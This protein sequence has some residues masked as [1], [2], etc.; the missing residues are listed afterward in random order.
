MAAAQS[1]VT[2]PGKCCILHPIMSPLTP[3]GAAESGAADSRVEFLP[4]G[5]SVLVP[6][7]STLV[8]AA[9]AAD[10]RIHAPCG[11][12]GRCG[13]CAV[14]MLRGAGPPTA[15]ESRVLSP[16]ELEAG[17]RLACQAR[18]AQDAQVDIP[19]SA[20]IVA[21]HIVV[22]G[23]GREVLVEPNVTKVALRLPPPSADDPRDDLNRVL[24]A[25]GH[26]TNGGLLP[27]GSLPPLAEL[28]RVL[29][30]SGWHVT[31]VVA[32]RN[33]GG[34]GP[35]L[36]G[37]EPG[38]TGD[39][40]YGV[41]V[42]IG[43][44]TLVVYLS[45]LPSGNLVS[46]ASDLNPQSQYGEDVISRLQ[47]AVAGV[48]TPALQECVAQAIDRLVGSAAAEGGIPRERIYEISVVGNTCMSHLFLGIDPV[49][50]VRLPFV[51]AFRRAQT[52][53]AA[54]LGISIHPE[55]QVYLLPNIGGWVGA[56]TVGVI[57]A[58]ELDQSKGL[59]VA[60]DIGTNGEIVVSQ[61][62][63][64]WACS[65]AAGPAFEGA[66]ISQGMRAAAGAIDH[67]AINGDVACHVI[68][69]APPV[70]I[71]GSG[72]V[73]AVAALVRLGVVDER[74]RLRGREEVEGLPEKVGE[75]LVQNEA[76]RAFVLAR[77]E[78]SGGRPVAITAR[79]IRESQLAKGAIYAGIA[80]VLELL[81]RTPGDIER[82][83][84]AGAFGNYIRR[85]SA[86]AIGL[87]PAIPEERIF[88]VGNA[89]GLGA[90]LALCSTSLRQRAEE[91]ARRTHHI[92]LSEQEGF[93]D[94]FAEAMALR[95]LPAAPLEP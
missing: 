38:D 28:P 50:L 8:A 84:L 7:Q 81:G 54:D 33:G 18:V 85:E 83:L 94:C 2:G 19:A 89:A 48:G 70:G 34:L 78:E 65:T 72:L 79:D 92:E 39:E 42:D 57:L 35:A 90:R 75:R 74:G 68:G 40:A 93:Y 32:G 55:G 60:V 17:W 88:S 56:D 61:D 80:L 11:G 47:V 36:L 59:Q 5:R 69:G 86:I 37:V 77:A 24:D 45:H 66:K 16:E 71:C 9:A 58:S 62:G 15:A 13:K 91:I 41:A 14:R 73:D 46:I 12:Q 95:P 26:A 25:M 31:A 53:R 44:T 3:T 64:L 21:H 4:S 6:A 51:P 23:L 27:P 49:G 52:V 1:S 22:E 43:T 30:T 82:L 76:G 63:E 67:V 29:R 20:L 10:L 87:V